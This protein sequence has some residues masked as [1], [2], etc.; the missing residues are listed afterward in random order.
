MT[1]TA[2][3]ANQFTLDTIANNATRD[4][5]NEL[6]NAESRIRNEIG[7][8]KFKTAYDAAIIGNPDADPIDN[9][10][11]TPEQIL[12]R[13]HFIDDGFKVGRDPI[14]GFWLLNWGQ[15]GAEIITSVY[16]IRTTVT[17]GAISQQT[18][19][20]IDNFFNTL[21]LRAT[22]ETVLNGDIM[23]EDFG[24]P[25]SVFYEYTSKANQQDDADNSVGLKSALRASGLGYV[26]DTRI[27]GV[28]GAA[29]T[30][31]NTNTIDVSN[32][33]TTVTVTVGGTGT[34]VD[35]VTAINSNATLLALSIVG[36]INGPD[37]LI[38]NNL[39]GTLIATNNAGDV[40]GDIFGL[41][42]PQTGVLTDNTEVY[43]LA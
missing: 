29:N 28:G 30:T 21:A 16:S 17:P 6:Q 34:A 40:L 35:L 42:S 19:D 10:N 2:G 32:G 11:L 14:N 25:N 38:I 26:D 20:V 41:S 9:A 18:I 1:I 15:V 4:V 24:A 8:E 5:T 36:D 22:S 31:V 13:D 33:T 12:F 43:K 23:E 39:A 3:Q 37:V 27:L 7:L